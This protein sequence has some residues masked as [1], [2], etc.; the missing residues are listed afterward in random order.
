MNKED[1]WVSSISVP[2]KSIGASKINDV[3]TNMSDGEE[4][5]PWNIYSPLWAPVKIEKNSMG[6]KYLVLRDKDRYD[7]AKAV[8][9]FKPG[10]DIDLSFALTPSQNNGTLYV[11]LQ[12]KKGDIAVTLLFDEQ[13]AIQ[14]SNLQTYMKIDDYEA[15]KEY[16]IRIR[17]G[18]DGKFDASVNGN[19]KKGLRL[20]SSH[21]GSI[22]RIVFR[23][24]KSFGKP[25]A[26]P[27]PEDAQLQIDPGSIDL[28]YCGEAENEVSFFIKSLQVESR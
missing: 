26:D 21:I 19:E 24:G 8:R 4:L 1:I 22:E 28:P 6:E 17:T 25:K 16:E 3:F 2:V 23:T 20:A 27:V 11:E 14:L 9:I 15:G 18:S 12:N 7:Y 5:S 10:K 13:G